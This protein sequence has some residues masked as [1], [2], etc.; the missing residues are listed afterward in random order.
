MTELETIAHAKS[1]LEK[2]AN[3]INPL[4]GEAVPETDLINQ[5]RISRCLFFVTDILQK[6][7]EQ[8]GV[9][10]PAKIQKI[11]FSISRETIDEFRFSDTPI[12]VSEITNRI[13]ALIDE[14][15]MK[16]LKYGSITG[17]LV[18][19]G[20]LEAVIVSDGKTVKRPT[21]AGQRI[22]LFTEQ[23]D[24]AYGP[25]QVT[26]YSL[27]AQHFVIDNLEAIIEN[28][29][30]PSEKKSVAENQGR[31]W[32][33]NEE[34]KLVELFHEGK[35]VSELASFFKRTET[36][37]RARLKKLGLIDSRGDAE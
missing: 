20:F 13:N 7:I 15:N 23:R 36:G 37:V 6:V 25:Y 5:V 12:P 17:F 4:T 27:E 3:G 2:M 8:G 14:N 32:F 26:L 1:Y 22:G 21:E 28:N 29:N 18:D 30:T 11:P 35:S 24:G 19:C 9:R 16:K 34:E 10:P 31:T 33:P